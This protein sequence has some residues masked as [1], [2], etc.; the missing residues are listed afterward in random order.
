MKKTHASCTTDDWVPYP[1]DR[2]IQRLDGYCIIVPNDRSDGTPLACSICDVLL[3][4]RDDEDAQL[5]FGCCNL[6]AL[7]WAHPRRKE[8]AA[9]WRPK[10]EDVHASV[11]QRPP[12]A[13]TFDVD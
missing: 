11:R 7:H 12:L 10:Q 13:I 4:S 1:N 2:L 9:G 6:C 5:E 8:W 3:R